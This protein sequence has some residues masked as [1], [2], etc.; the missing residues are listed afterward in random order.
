M[1]SPVVVA[2]DSLRALAFRP[3][4]ISGNDSGTDRG[5][6][7]GNL[8]DFGATVDFGASGTGRRFFWFTRRARGGVSLR[9]SSSNASSAESALLPGRNLCILATCYQVVDAGEYRQA[10]TTAHATA[11][12]AELNFGHSKTRPTGRTLRNQRFQ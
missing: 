3:T 8:V 2:S 6:G 5:V 12:D 4:S 1:M 11:R 10:R 7:R 9:N